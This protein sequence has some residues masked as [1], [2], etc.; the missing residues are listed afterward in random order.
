MDSNSVTTS[1]KDKWDTDGGRQSLRSTKKDSRESLQ[2]E[3]EDDNDDKPEKN[4]TWHSDSEQEQVS[5]VD[6][7]R[8]T[9]SFYSDEYDS[10]SEGSRSPYSQSRIP[11]HSP[12]RRLQAKTSYSTPINKK[13]MHS[14]LLNTCYLLK[15]PGDGSV[16]I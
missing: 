7:R 3:E 2:R 6:G 4:R 11:S 1:Y 5:D 13:G 12:Q 8:S 16:V 9:L 14:I 15:Y 10:P